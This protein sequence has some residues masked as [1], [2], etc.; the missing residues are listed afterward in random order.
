[1]KSILITIRDMFQTFMTYGISEC[2]LCIILCIILFIG[3][4][5]Y[6]VWFGYRTI[7]FVKKNYKRAH[8]TTTVVIVCALIVYAFFTFVGVSIFCYLMGW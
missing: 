8:I 1:M 4:V 7:Y 6:L 5:T 3:L 2:I